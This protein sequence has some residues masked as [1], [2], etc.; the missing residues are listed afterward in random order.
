MGERMSGCR[1]PPGAP[2][3]EVTRPPPPSPRGDWLERRCSL[4]RRSQPRPGEGHGAATVD[5]DAAHRLRL[6]P[7]RLPERAVVDPRCHGTAARLAPQV[8]SVAPVEAAAVSAEPLG[9]EP[10]PA[11]IAGC[12]EARPGG[13]VGHGVDR[14]VD[15]ACL[16][17]TWTEVLPQPPRTAPG[18]RVD[19]ERPGLYENRKLHPAPVLLAGVHRQRNLGQR[20]GQLGATADTHENEQASSGIKEWHRRNRADRRPTYFLVPSKRAVALSHRRHGRWPGGITQHRRRPEVPCSPC[21]FR[22]VNPKSGHPAP[23]TK[24]G[25]A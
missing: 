5:G 2:R 6:E 25:H 15:A 9:H 10:G 13:T 21:R 20:G 16:R 24:G 19:G 12:D 18:V 11:H 1:L 23:Q 17:L 8:G 7:H 4:P 22:H 14:R 3:P